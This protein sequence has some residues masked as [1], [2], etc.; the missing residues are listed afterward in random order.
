MSDRDYHVPALGTMAHSWVQSFDSEYESFKAYAETYP[1]ACTVLVDTYNVL[2]SGVPNAIR[3]AKEVLE[4]AGH[5]LKGV[6]IDSGDIAYLSQQTR[7]MLDEAGLQDC[8][9][10]VSNSLDEFLVLDLL[11][12]GAC[13]N[14]FG[15]GERLITAKSA[16]VFGGVYKLVAIDDKQGGI[17]PKI[18]ISENVDKITNPHFKQVWRLTDRSDRKYRADVLTLRDEVIDDNQPYLLFDPTHTWKRRTIT[19]Y[20][21]R[22]LQ[23]QLFDKGVC[24]HKARD[25]QEIR[26]F[27][28]ECQGR[29][30]NAVSRFENPHPYYVDLSQ[31]LWDI[32]QRL[33]MENSR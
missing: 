25:I 4:P 24:V 18:K 32:K 3:V 2:K 10:V 13:I 9:I 19:D 15:I 14:S 27:C 6:R 17:I 28:K 11:R 7:R 29:I 8:G 23:V 1:D 12:Q 33:L 5:R 21:A 30:W 20:E 22:P 16:P 26:A 31:K